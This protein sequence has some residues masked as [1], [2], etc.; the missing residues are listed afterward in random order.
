MKKIIFLNF[1]VILFMSCFLCSAQTVKKEVQNSASAKIEA[2]YFHN[3]A[4]C[5]TCKAVEAEAKA[6]LENLYGK[7]VTFQ[8]LNLEEEATKP[9]A[10]KLKVSGQTLLIVIGDK[11]INLTNEGFMYART[12]PEKFKSIIKA[13]VDKLLG[14]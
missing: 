1:A 3:T 9:T 4:R 6:D 14:L 13:K 10:E 7:Q 2:Y 11:K 8:E 5:V 12:N